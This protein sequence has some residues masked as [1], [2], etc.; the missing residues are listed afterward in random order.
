MSGEVWFGSERLNGKKLGY[1]FA[2]RVTYAIETFFTTSDDRGSMWRICRLARLEPDVG[3]D[4]V[5][6]AF[7]CI[8]GISWDSCVLDLVDRDAEEVGGPECGRE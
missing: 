6:R 2:Q 1:C 8:G 4:L 5:H 3:P 7:A